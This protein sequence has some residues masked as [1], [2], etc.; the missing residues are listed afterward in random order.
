M[1]YKKIEKLCKEI[2]ISLACLER[3]AGLGKGAISKWRTSSPTVDNLKAVAN[4]LETTV[5]KLLEEKPEEVP[6]EIPNG[7]PV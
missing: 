3:E 4:V 6:E 1:L 5:D 2:G 7:I